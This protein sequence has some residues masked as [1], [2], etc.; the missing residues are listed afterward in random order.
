VTDANCQGTYPVTRLFHL[1]WFAEIGNDHGCS[2]TNKAKSGH[3]SGLSDNSSSSDSQPSI[4]SDSDTDSNSDSD[5]D[6]DDSP[7]GSDGRVSP[8]T[9]GGTDQVS[10]EP[11]RDCLIVA[12]DFGFPVWRPGSIACKI[13]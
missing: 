1:R 4:G 3:S 13:S 5:S 9:Q 2:R 10:D 7:S 8:E 6:S 12:S 11:H